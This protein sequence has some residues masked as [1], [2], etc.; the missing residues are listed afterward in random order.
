MVRV[1]RE[2]RLVHTAPPVSRDCFFG[3]AFGPAKFVTHGELNDLGRNTNG[4]DMIRA[5]VSLMSDAGAD[6]LGSCLLDGGIG[7]ETSLTSLTANPQ[8]E[9]C[10]DYQWPVDTLGDLDGAG[11]RRSLA[12]SLYCSRRLSPKRPYC[13]RVKR[14]A[15]RNYAEHNGRSRRV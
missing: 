15:A 13:E 10:G 9:H 8:Q 14:A 1:A 12:S 3:T 11:P 2:G 4:C 5:G 7:L 6:A